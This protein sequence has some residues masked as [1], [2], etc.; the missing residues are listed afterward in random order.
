MSL[1]IKR[2]SD[3]K[4]D[5][6]LNTTL[7]NS[8]K[9]AAD[10]KS[11]FNKF[12]EKKR[13]FKN[14]EMLTSAF[15]PSAILHRDTEI[16]FL[17]NALAPSLLLERISNILIYGFSGTGKSLVTRYVCQH[18]AELSQEKNVNV[19]PIY[20]NCRLENNNTEYRLL[21]NLCRILGVKVPISGLSANDL[22]KKMVNAIDDREKSIILILDEIEK[23][24]QKAGDGVLYSLLRL[25][26]SMRYA[27]ISIIGISNNTDLKASL[28]QRVRSSLSPVE[29]VFK[30]YNAVH[31]A[32]ILNVRTQEAFYQNAINEGI[33]NKTAAL[34]AREHGDVRKAI[35]MLRVAGEQAQQRGS[36]EIM[37]QDLN[38]AIEVLEQDITETSI[39]NMTKQS[40]CVMLSI[41]TASRSKRMGKVY[42][43][44]VYDSYTRLSARYGLEKLT[45]RRISDL[46]ADMDY[47][48]L[49]MSRVT[50]K[51]RGGRMRELNI[52]FSP[53]IIDKVEE[54]LKHDLSD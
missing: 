24:I 48:S 43:A 50:S 28:D 10:P 7:D 1:N 2:L 38:K 53:M 21:S 39:R 30:P 3:S 18:L 8:E 34:A 54:M 33:I 6:L 16:E 31:I 23:L 40:K 17:S 15:V 29:F 19:T 32:D 4:Q 37:E 52:A 25:N 45:F 51:G 20:V 5:A 42:S 9:Q 36:S 14:K 13:I 47:S 35:N 41:I 49:I 26:E 44:E 12:L 11:I 22:Y 27:K 46:I